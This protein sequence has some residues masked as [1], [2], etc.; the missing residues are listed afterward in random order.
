MSARVPPYQNTLSACLFAALFGPL[1]NLATAVVWLLCVQ[2][3]H[4]LFDDVVNSTDLME[5]FEDNEAVFKAIAIVYFTVVTYMAILVLASLFRRAN[6]RAIIIVYSIT[7]VSLFF[8]LSWDGYQI[9][10][11]S[12]QVVVAITTIAMMLYTKAGQLAPS[13]NGKGSQESKESLAEAPNAIC[14]DTPAQGHANAFTEMPKRSM[15][16][17]FLGIALIC[18][19]MPLLLSGLLVWKEAYFSALGLFA[20]GMAAPLV[21]YFNWRRIGKKP[22][23]LVIDEAGL[24]FNDGT[25]PWADINRVWAASEHSVRVETDMLTERTFLDRHRSK[26][27]WSSELAVRIERIWAGINSI[28]IHV[29]HFEASAEDIVAAIERDRPRKSPT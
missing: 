19:A 23:T 13:R 27:H 22:K 15:R 7:T 4:F 9:A 20:V 12:Y 14:V 16:N 29:A 18:A 26:A 10:Q 25:L 24:N 28:P 17:I 6:L 1:L 8:Y 11:L 21:L 3:A 5:F 2:F